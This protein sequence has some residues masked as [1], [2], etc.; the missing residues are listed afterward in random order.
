MTDAEQTGAPMRGVETET[1]RNAAPAIST[2]G[3]EGLVQEQ[4]LDRLEAAGVQV[5]IDIRAVPN[6]RKPGFSKKI[7]AASAEARGVR[8]VHIQALGTPKAGRIAARAGRGEEMARIF[9]AHLQTE[10]AQ[11]GLVAAR[12]IASG[13]PCCLLCF[14]RDPHLCHR[15]IV[16]EVIAAQTG[17]QVVHL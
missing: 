16:A 15:R 3:Y 13:A 4:L 9:G 2:A 10:A 12:D 6:S 14:E 11:A 1:G 7:L 17:Q 5:L 8:Y